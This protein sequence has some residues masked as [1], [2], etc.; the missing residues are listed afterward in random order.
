MALALSSAR[1]RYIGSPLAS[2]FSF[3]MFHWRIRVPSL[4]SRSVLFSM[5][6][7]AGGGGVPPLLTLLINTN[8]SVYFEVETVPVATAPWSK[9]TNPGFITAD[10]STWINLDFYFDGSSQKI[11]KDNVEATYAS[12]VVGGASPFGIST[13]TTLYIGGFSGSAESSFDL[14]E[15]C[16]WDAGA[17]SMLAISGYRDMLIAG[18]D[19][20]F[21]T[22]YTESGSNRPGPL[23]YIKATGD[24]R[25]NS[26]LTPINEIG[27]AGVVSVSGTPT[28]VEHPLLIEPA[29]VRRGGGD[30]FTPEEEED[31]ICYSIVHTHTLPLWNIDLN[32]VE[33]FYGTSG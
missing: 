13:D 16:I 5:Y 26:S 3:H 20:G 23:F 6:D 22:D 19:P 28:Y 8:G 7:P 24:V 11:Y 9:L 30:D 33:A 12:T 10:A 1:L 4:A 15:M 25:A 2:V 27:Q 31:H 17:N 14:A 29:S 18:W 32:Q 21:L